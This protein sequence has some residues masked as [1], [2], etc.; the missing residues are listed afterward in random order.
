MWP[1][2]ATNLA[3]VR[4]LRG[5]RDAV[6]LAEQAAAVVGEPVLR[7]ATA[8]ALAQARLLAGDPA[9]A[10]VA[11]APVIEVEPN[12]YREPN[13]IRAVGLRLDALIATDRRDEAREV[14]A[15]VETTAAG[16]STRWTRA[17]A[18]QYRGVLADTIDDAETA[19]AAALAE[20]L[21]EDGRIEPGLIRLNHGRWLRRAGHRLAARTQLQQAHTDFT[22]AGAAAFADI[23]A[24]EIATTA[25]RLR[26]RS[27]PTGHELTAREAEI[28]RHAANGETDKDIAAALYIGVRTVDFHL[29]NVF[30]KLGIRSRSELATHLPDEA[31]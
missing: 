6:A 21:P 22:S 2:C 31:R 3:Y 11:L 8:P 14:L 10:L 5:D 9:G 4:V 13:E 20:L 15:Q 26:P 1:M 16:S 18:A 25:A 30:R 23:T 19:F 28:A 7:V 29:R 24:R 27:A 17:I 12:G